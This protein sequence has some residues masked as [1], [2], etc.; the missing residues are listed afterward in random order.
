[1]NKGRLTVC[2]ETL[3]SCIGHFLLKR[4]SEELSLF[5]QVAAERYLAEEPEEFGQD[6]APTTCS[7]CDHDSKAAIHLAVVACGDRMPGIIDLNWTV[8]CLVVLWILRLRVKCVF[9]LSPFLLLLQKPL[10]YSSPL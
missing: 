8:H 9:F 4:Y 1:M 5:K 2:D 3:F 7:N 6:S 10:F